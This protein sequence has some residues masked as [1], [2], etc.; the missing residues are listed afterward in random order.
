[1]SM[2][3]EIGSSTL[4]LPASGQNDHTCSTGVGKSQQGMVDHWFKTKK[5]KVDARSAIKMDHF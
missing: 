1:M 3:E 4:A 2:N 5:K